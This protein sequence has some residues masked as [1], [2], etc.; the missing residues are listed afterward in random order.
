VLVDCTI[1]AVTSESIDG[2]C[3]GIIHVPDGYLTFGG[4]GAFTSKAKAKHWSISGG[5]GPYANDRGEI[6]SAHESFVVT[7]AS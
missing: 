6:A 4:N 3:S 1:L 7:L 2:V 5:V